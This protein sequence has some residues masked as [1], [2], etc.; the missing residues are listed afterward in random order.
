M[1]SNQR[2][3][4]EVAVYIVIGALAIPS[5]VGAVLLVETPIQ[6]FLL[7]IAADF[8]GVAFLFFLVN[9]FFALDS[10]DTVSN[11]VDRLIHLAEQGFNVLVEEEEARQ[12]LDIKKLLTTC[13]QLDILSFTLTEFL[14]E[15]QA[16]ISECVCRGARVRILV[17][18]PQST[19]RE[20]IYQNSAEH[21][22]YDRDIVLTLSYIQKIQEMIAGGNK[23]VKGGFDFKLTKWIPSC[24][25]IIVDPNL[26][27][28]SSM[29]KVTLHSPH[30]KTP[31]HESNLNIVFSHRD[32]PKWF[33]YFEE[34]FNRLWEESYLWNGVFPQFPEPIYSRQRRN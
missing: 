6:D 5:F 30:Y 23:Q 28:E 33:G 10:E 17:I 34:Q 27:L 18:D 1:K 20:V 3:K 14:H 8:F 32:Q 2:R 26:K 19:A 31:G 15:F 22:P 13:H 11:Q 29:M 9:R 25:L 24:G 21:R 16:Q 12:R 7:N 4:L